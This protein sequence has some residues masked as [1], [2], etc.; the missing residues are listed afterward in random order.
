M[1]DDMT[2]KSSLRIYRKFK[3]EIKENDNEGG[4]ESR[5]WF[6]ARMRSFRLACR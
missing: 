5:I 6:A 1:M 4:M 2:G 3:T